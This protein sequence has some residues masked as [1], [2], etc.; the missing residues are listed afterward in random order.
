M[1]QLSP[2]SKKLAKSGNRGEKKMAEVD[3][4]TSAGIP[5]YPTI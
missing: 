3:V 4:P 1:I 5:R 2:R